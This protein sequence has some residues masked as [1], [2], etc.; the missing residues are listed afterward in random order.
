MSA[1]VTSRIDHSSFRTGEPDSE[2]AHIAMRGCCVTRY[3][4]HWRSAF[5]WFSRLVQA[6][7]LRGAWPHLPCLLEL[8]VFWIVG[9]VLCVV[10]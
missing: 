1:I 3:I 6:S 10:S 7:L 5:G 9:M 8:S 2:T 4:V